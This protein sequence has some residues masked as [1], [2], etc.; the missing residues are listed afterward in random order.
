M[1]PNLRFALGAIL[2]SLVLVVT[3]F[4][5]ATTVRL[6]HYTKVA[7]FDTTRSLAFAD[8]GDR[9]PF[10]DPEAARRHDTMAERTDVAA[11]D[12]ALER[13][14][15]GAWPPVAGPTG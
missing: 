9:N 5:L 15:R 1:L 14:A 2:A 8:F 11:I 6:A 7:P 4:G 13:A 3:V 10:Y 12:A